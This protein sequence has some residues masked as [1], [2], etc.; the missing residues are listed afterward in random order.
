MDDRVL[1]DAEVGV[2]KAWSGGE[3]GRHLVAVPA[4]LAGEDE[5]RVVEVFGPL[6][7]R[8]EGMPPEWIIYPSETG[9]FVTEDFSGRRVV[10]ATLE[11]AL[12][13]L[14]D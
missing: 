8:D 11:A 1:S 9:G 3:S 14:L 7:T 13:A 6:G 4:S 5:H 12:S 2:A 10:S